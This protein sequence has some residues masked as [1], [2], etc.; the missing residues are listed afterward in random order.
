[1][2]LRGPP[3]PWPFTELLSHALYTCLSDW[4][5]GGGSDTERE[6]GLL[7]EGTV[8]KKGPLLLLIPQALRRRKLGGGPEL[9]VAPEPEGRS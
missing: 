5:V 2:G 8:G 4:M 3:R 7:M 1:M 9:D 6:K